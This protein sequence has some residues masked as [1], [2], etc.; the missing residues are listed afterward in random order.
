VDF[1][2]IKL[3][4][5][6]RQRGSLFDAIPLRQNPRSE[7]DGKLIQGNDL[8]MVQSLPLESGVGLRFVA[9]PS[10]LTIVSDYVR[11]ATQRQYSDEAFRTELIHWLRFDKK[12]ALSSGDGLYSGCSGN[13]EV[14]RWLGRMFVA[15]GNHGS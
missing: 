13:P 5:D 6:T 8:D 14:Q 2:H 4:A 9:V 15:G 1:I 11:H 10:S 12:E 3:T 7:F